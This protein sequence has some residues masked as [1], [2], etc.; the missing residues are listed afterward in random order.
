MLSAKLDDWG[1]ATWVTVV[2]PLTVLV[3]TETL[4]TYLMVLPIRTEMSIAERLRRKKE[5]RETIE[6]R[7]SLTVEKNSRVAQVRDTSMDGIG[8]KKKA[9]RTIP[10]TKVEIQRNKARKKL[11]LKAQKA[12]EK[13]ERK[14]ERAA[15]RIARKR[16]DEELAAQPER[17]R[18]RDTSLP[19]SDSAV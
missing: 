17:G 16:A 8:H 2:T 12:K 11:F 3:V 18:R 19:G 10:L 14:V 9:K 4:W 6:H 1:S 13:A 7:R 5:R 15:K